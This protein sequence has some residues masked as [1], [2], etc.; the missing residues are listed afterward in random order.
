MVD[1]T[2]QSEDLGVRISKIFSGIV[3]FHLSY[4]LTSFPQKNIDVDG[5]ELQEDFGEMYFNHCLASPHGSFMRKLGGNLFD[6]FSNIDG[7]HD[8]LNRCYADAKIP[9]LNVERKGEREMTVT[10]FSHRDDLESII[11]GIVCLTAKYQILFEKIH[12]CRNAQY[13][14]AKYI[15]LNYTVEST[16]LR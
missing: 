12:F 10:Y 9:S 11:P 14:L 3:I 13:L 6:L 15:P 4:N 2:C 7:L 8:Y 5:Q 1:K 16:H